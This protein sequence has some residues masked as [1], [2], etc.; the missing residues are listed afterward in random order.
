MVRSITS[1]GVMPSAV[2]RSAIFSRAISSGSAYPSGA[3]RRVVFRRA[4]SCCLLFGQLATAEQRLGLV[5]AQLLL[6]L[7]AA[8]Q[9]T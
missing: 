8:A 1:N 3:R 4:L 6:L 7:Q 5:A 2:A 9:N